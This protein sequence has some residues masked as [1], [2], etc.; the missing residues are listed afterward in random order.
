MIACIKDELALYVVRRFVVFHSWRHTFD[1][2]MKG[3]SVPKDRRDYITGHAVGDVAELDPENET[4][5]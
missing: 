4:V 3:V 2:A 1:T 5:G